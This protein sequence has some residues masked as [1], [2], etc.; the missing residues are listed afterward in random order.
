MAKNYDLTNKR[1][2]RLFVI[3]LKEKG[4]SKYWEC[5]CDCGNVISVTTTHLITGHTVSCGCK[6]RENRE[7]R[8]YK[9]GLCIKSRRLYGIY[10]AMLNRCLNPLNAQY[11]HY[12]GRGITVCKEWKDDIQ[13]FFDWAFSNGYNDSLSIDRIDSDGNYEP[14]NCRWATA[15]EQAN[16]KR[17]IKRR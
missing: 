13:S 11:K 2:G 6:S 1:F 15:K 5:S 4:K 9:H 12:G 3:C 16:N 17:N 10:H 7:R 8:N 14:S